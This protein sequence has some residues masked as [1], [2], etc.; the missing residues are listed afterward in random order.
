[1]TSSRLPVL[2]A[3]VTGIQVGA[4]IVASKFVIDQT[5]PAALAMLRYG[6][7]F[8]CLAPVV[9]AISRQKIALRDIIPVSILGILQ[10]GILIALLNYALQFIPSARAALILATFPLQTM[11]LAALLG[12]ENLTW[13]KSLGVL[14]TLAGIAIALGSDIFTQSSDTPWIGDAAVALSAFCGAVCSIYY[15]PYLER[16]PAQNV[17]ALAMLA[18]VGFLAI[19]AASEQSLSG[20]GHIDRSGWYAIIFIGIS[21]GIGY[22]TWLWALKMMS[23]TRVTMFLALSPITSAALGFLWLGEEITLSFA[24]GLALVILGLWLAMRGREAG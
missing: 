12:R 14:A 3:V 4:A 15:R 22:F 9:L 18:S 8:L 11:V 21:S 24:I 16:Y 10:F 17:S 19:L 7:G 13:F 5:T 6:I 20:I 2:A 1:M 23:P